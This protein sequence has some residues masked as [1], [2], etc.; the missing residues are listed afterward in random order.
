MKLVNIYGLGEKSPLSF[1]IPS[2][3]KKLK[4]VEFP[5]SSKGV[6]GVTLGFFAIFTFFTV[7]SMIMKTSEN[8]KDVA[9]FFIYFF[10]FTGIIVS[11]GSYM[12]P[13]NIFYTQR[14]MSYNEEM[15]KAIMRISTY[16]SM[17]SSME[18]AG[19]VA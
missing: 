6:V 11:L 13:V 10:A 4:F 8:F 2:V 1:S 9:D 3:E 18:F 14:M 5:Y 19:T 15:L 17:N 12:Y 7:M 16:I